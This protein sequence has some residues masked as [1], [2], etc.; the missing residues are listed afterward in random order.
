MTSPF[1]PGE[2]QLQNESGVTERMHK[3]GNIVLRNH[4]ID[5]HRTFFEALP[6]VFV[7][8]MDDQNRPWASIIQSDAQLMSVTQDDVLEIAGKPLGCDAM[9]LQ[10]G[11]GDSVGV[12]GLDL[13]NRRRNR[14]N[15][16]L[17]ATDSDALA[18][19]VH[20]SFG[21]CPK[22]IQIREQV[23]DPASSVSPTVTRLTTLDTETCNLICSADTFFI[24][25]TEGAEKGIPM[26]MS[27]RGGKPGFVSVSK[28]D[29]LVWQDY[30]GNN[31]YQTFGNLVNYPE[32]GLLFIDFEQGDLVHLV[33]KATVTRVGERESFVERQ[34]SFEFYEGLRIRN[35]LT[36]HWRMVEQSP[37]LPDET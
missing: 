23:A 26:D 13:T 2:L 24:A 30:P 10:L 19:K 8:A 11:S 25:S 14:L 29:T 37:Y 33:G 15:G 9:N 20:H 7:S 32:C 22:Y 5:Q 4:I 3:I 16:T 35:A 18:V 6:Y 27:H 1:H 34:V 28:Y 17:L 31:L 12:L 21:N 36:S